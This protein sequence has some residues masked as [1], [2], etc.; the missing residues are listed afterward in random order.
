MRRAFNPVKRRVPGTVKACI[1]D[2]F[3][4]AGGPKRVMVKLQLGEAQTYAFADPESPEQ[5]SFARV[6]ALTGRDAPAAAEYLADLAGGV[7]MPLPH[8][9]SEVGA[10]TVEAV[11]ESGEAAADL[12]QALLD[13]RLTPEEAQRALPN[14][15]EALQAFARLHA[16]VAAIA[17]RG[18][19]E[20]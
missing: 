6:A 10:L 17:R 3:A 20:G 14:L 11:R 19:G 4:Q 18:P 8:D 15:G 12:V 2:L 9:G 5:I 13:G 7:F 1:V 16:T